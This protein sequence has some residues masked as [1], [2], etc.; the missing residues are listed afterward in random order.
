[1]RGAVAVV[2]AALVLTGCGGGADVALPGPAR[3]DVDSPQLR[4]MKAQ[5]GVEDC[6]PSGGE[7]V[8]GG[9]PAVTLPCF[10]GGPD[11][12][13][14]ALRGP[15]VVNLWASWCGPCRQ[16]M[17]VL[18]AFHEQYGDRVPVLGVDWQ[19][20]QTQ[21]GMELVQTT[22]VTYPLLAD[23]NGELA[24]IDG[25]VVRGLPGLVLLDAD[26]RVS[27]RNLEVVHDEA[28]LVGLVD[29]HLGITL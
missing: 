23:P 21:A 6:S 2:A 5:A 11:V 15:M 17:P 14:G 1:M 7:H 18:Q 9:L 13:L 19:D 12:D 27:Y 4:Q 20:P 29:E 16:E 22:G 25:M 8:D 3:I 10:G 28:Q 26:G 24:S